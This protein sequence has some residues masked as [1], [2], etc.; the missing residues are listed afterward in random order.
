LR[1]TRTMIL[2]SRRATAQERLP[3]VDIR[4]DTLVLRRGPLRQV[5]LCR[6]LPIALKDEEEQ[7]GF[8]H[9]WTELLHA[10]TH[11]IQVSVHIRP[12]EDRDL[13]A[14]RPHAV[15]S[16]LNGIASSYAALLAE[17][18]TQ[19]R[20][21]RRD[22]YVVVPWDPPTLARRNPTTSD[23]PFLRLEERTRTLTQSLNRTGVEGRHL[24][25]DELLRLLY[26]TINPVL[27]R[28]QALLPQ[29]LTL[30]E[31]Q[32]LLAPAAFVTSPDCFEAGDR[33]TRTLALIGYPRYLHLGWLDVFLSLRSALRIS[34]FIS[35]VPTEQALPFLEKKIAELASTVR[36]TAER[37]GRVDVERKA[38]LADAQ[39]LQDRLVRAEERFFDLAI[40][41]TVEAADAQTLED[42][43]TRLETA[44]GGLMV[45]TRRLLFQMEQG[46]WSTLPLGIDRVGIRR[47]MTTP[48]LRVTFP[49]SAS[50]YGQPLGQLYGVDPAS[51]SPVFLDRFL[52]PNANAVVLAQSGGGKSYAVK[53]EIL[54]A[55]LRGIDVCVLDPEGEYIA[56]AQTVQGHV[57]S[58]SPTSSE[59]PSVFALG[60]RI[61]SGACT[62][63]KLTVLGL[64]R[65]LIGGLSEV[66]G[67]ILQEALS[68]IYAFKG[69]SDE[70]ESYGCEPPDITDLLQT[71]EYQ[72]RQGPDA[73]TARLLERR[74]RSLSEG[75]SGWLLQGR[76]AISL[77]TSGLNVIALPNLPEETRS[78]AM[79]LVLDRLWEHLRQRPERRKTFLVIDEAWWL[80]RQPDTARFVY[81]L[82]KTARKLNVGLTL[83]TQDVLDLLS[84][85][86][87]KT[88]IANS[89]VQV[90]FRQS[91]RSIPELADCFGL[92]KAEGLFLMS[93]PVGEGILMGRNSRTRLQV[94]ASAAEDAVART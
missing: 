23:S 25:D 11:P 85:D 1:F 13:L 92:T 62:E 22:F 38:A 27:G 73:D 74:L 81:R 76:S 53:V 41:A 78:A 50:D 19:A 87:G 31:L 59:V 64:V 17:L 84:S 40:Y 51:G 91:A 70:P 21:V 89:S 63:R 32:D 5:L 90:L 72:A 48:G 39:A 12:A 6:P 10:L 69:V 65:Q 18:C 28:R 14:V 52:L 3:V 45:K 77:Q 79:F 80:V 24:K 60:G 37:S 75:P 35:P 30:N 88:V 9:S 44:L 7:A 86:A 49:F 43:S 56:L 15:S 55:L 34:L 29:D 8:L 67:L 93:A 36:F 83:I 4:H 26:H 33:K 20:L 46:Y 47:N 58:I 57:E 61:T 54:R 2:A 66:E 82:A 71:L 16:V 94:L 68:R 42:D